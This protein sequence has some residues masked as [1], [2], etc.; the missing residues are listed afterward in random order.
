MRIGEK[1]IE[2]NSFDF[3]LI[4]PGVSHL[5]Y[6]SKYATFDNYVIHFEEREETD[7]SNK[8]IKLHD[9]DGAVK[10]LCT[11]IY[12]LYMQSKLK[13]IELINIYLQGVLYHMKRGLVVDVRP[14]VSREDEI[15]D[16][17]S[18]IVNANIKI[19]PIYV[20]D[21]A[22]ELNVSASYLARIFSKRLGMPPVKYIIEVKLASAKELLRSTSLSIKEVSEMLYFSDSLYFSR[23][24]SEYE[25][26]S[27]REWRKLNMDKPEN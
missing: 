26:V 24:F 16:M 25:G 12:S 22:D 8:V 1:D 5:L 21:L 19:K 11:Q 2:Y 10:Y 7:V 14:H 20:K 18:K 9:Y 27:P 13:E 15:I 6:E 3:L 17:A 4:P 23:V